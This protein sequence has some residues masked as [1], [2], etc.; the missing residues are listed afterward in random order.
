M[1]CISSCPTSADYTQFYC[2]SDADQAAADA[3]TADGYIL[4]SDDQC[5][6]Q[7][8]TMDGTICLTASY[9]VVI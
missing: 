9:D 5:M 1:V 8:K 6:V 7:V 3:L 4:M 2:R